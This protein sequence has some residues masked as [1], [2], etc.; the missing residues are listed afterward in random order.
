MF[1]LWSYVYISKY[2]YEISGTYFCAKVDDF[3]A[4]CGLQGFLESMHW[5]LVKNRIENC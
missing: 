2:E 3:W 1:L 4:N 5:N